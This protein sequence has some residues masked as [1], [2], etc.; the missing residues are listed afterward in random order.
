M[1]DRST[2]LAAQIVGGLARR[3]SAATVLFHHAVAERVGLG[4][5][6]ARECLDLVCENAVR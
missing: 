2:E 6:P 4:P 1:G 5:C 3:H